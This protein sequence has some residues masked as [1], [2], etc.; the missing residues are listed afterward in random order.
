M[1]RVTFT[2]TSS[3]QRKKI[4][5]KR[6]KLTAQSEYFNYGQYKK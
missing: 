6:Q 5:D 4:Y 3:E 1:G 2:P